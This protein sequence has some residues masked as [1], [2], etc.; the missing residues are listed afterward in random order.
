M[1]SRSRTT[2]SAGMTSPNP[3]ML[4]ASRVSQVGVP[5]L[6]QAQ[7]MYKSATSSGSSSAGMPATRRLRNG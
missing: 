4:V 3:A 1:M 7:D 2:A 6:T 5:N